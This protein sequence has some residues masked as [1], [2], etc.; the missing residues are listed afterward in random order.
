MKYGTTLFVCK[1]TLA[2]NSLQVVLD[3]EIENIRWLYI[4]AQQKTNPF[5]D[6]ERELRD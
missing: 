1:F 3:Q 6:V 2:S 5:D 4:D